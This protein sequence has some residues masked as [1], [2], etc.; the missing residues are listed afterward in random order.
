MICGRRKEYK[1]NIHILARVSLKS[2]GSQRFRAWHPLEH[3]K[4]CL[5]PC[6]R[7]MKRKILMYLKI[8]L[9]QLLIF[10]VFFYYGLCSLH[11]KGNVN[12][13]ETVALIF[14]QDQY[15]TE[16]CNK[17]SLSLSLWLCSPLDLSPF[18]FQ[19]FNHI[20]RQKYS[21]DGVSTRCKAAAYT[22]NNTSTQ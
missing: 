2:S 16:N 22:Q 9:I 8:Y 13:Q 6:K 18:F 7:N 5:D 21:L 11:I 14:L 17:C 20:H 15:Y 19:F 10:S 4:K 12:K 1:N 3:I